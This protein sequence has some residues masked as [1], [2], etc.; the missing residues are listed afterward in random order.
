[1]RWSA[2]DA[3]AELELDIAPAYATEAGAA[4]CRRVVRLD[5][6]TGVRV[7]DEYR[8]SRPIGRLTMSVLT[9]CAARAD[10]PGTVV[11]A[12]RE[13]V[14]G[15]RSASGVFAYDPEAFTATLERIG[16]DDARLSASW[17]KELTRVILTVQAPPREGA[18]EFRFDPA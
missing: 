11:L 15:R 4:A 18:F 1:M 5:R 17:G 16:I 9:P 7:R 10:A 12:E 13:I 6:A 2:D 8:L 14:D 3:G